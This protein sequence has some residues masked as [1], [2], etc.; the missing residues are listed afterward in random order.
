M[1]D[2]LV[3]PKPRLPAHSYQDARAE[4]WDL[5]LNIYNKSKR[6]P[7]PYGHEGPVRDIGEMHGHGFARAERVCSGVLWCKAESGCP[8]M[9]GLGPQDCD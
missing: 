9:N 4:G 8:D 7:L 1:T 2:C 5:L 6:A 3:V